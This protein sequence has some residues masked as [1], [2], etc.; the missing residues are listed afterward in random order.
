MAKKVCFFLTVMLPHR[1]RR[2]ITN[3]LIQSMYAL[4]HCLS[5]RAIF[6]NNTVC[7]TRLMSQTVQQITGGGKAHLTGCSLLV[8]E[9]LLS[10]V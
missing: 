5:R 6:L 1:R 4:K 2:R 10:S 3:P 9:H 8:A 7:K